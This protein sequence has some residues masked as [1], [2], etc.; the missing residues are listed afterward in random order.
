M[1]SVACFGVRISVMFHLMFVHY[2]F[3]SVWVAEGPPFGKYL[4]ARLV[5]CSYCLL[6]I[7]N[8]YS[9]SERNLAFDCA[10]SCS[11]LFYYFYG[12]YLQ[13]GYTMLSV[14]LISKGK[15]CWSFRSRMYQD[16]V[17][18]TYRPRQ[19]VH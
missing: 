16:L 2:I 6:S 15:W 5:I 3:S 8:F 1:V 9:F 19:G 14:L 4:P 13:F 12:Y 17:I 7:C 10:S 11:L 18:D